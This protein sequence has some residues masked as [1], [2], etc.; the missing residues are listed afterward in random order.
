MGVYVEV[1]LHD[2]TLLG[3]ME[4]LRDETEETQ[5]S[6]FAMDFGTYHYNYKVTGVDP[7]TKSKWG[8][9]GKVEHTRADWAWALVA[10][11]LS[12]KYW[13]R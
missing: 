12:D 5:S 13:E 8:Y 11:V 3:T 6:E 4:L 2:G 1:K 9:Q 7:V 10:K